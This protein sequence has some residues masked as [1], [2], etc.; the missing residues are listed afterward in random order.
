M[1]HLKQVLVMEKDIRKKILHKRLKKL[2][3]IYSFNEPILI[4]L[5]EREIYAEIKNGLQSFDVFT[6]C[7]KNAKPDTFKKFYDA[8]FELM[9]QG[10]LIILK[11]EDIDTF[12]DLGFGVDRSL[13]GGLICITYQIEKK[14]FD[15]SDKK[16]MGND[17]YWI[18][19]WI[20]IYNEYIEFYLPTIYK[21]LLT[22]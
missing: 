19:S 11:R 5:V 8:R 22:N 3:T 18:D 16:L 4:K 7:S 9:L 21:Q 1:K 6:F 10:Q 2:E 20:K 12:L 13:K 14:P 15:K 17:K